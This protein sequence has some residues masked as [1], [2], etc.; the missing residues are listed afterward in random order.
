M[1][2]QD[3]KAGDNV[4]LEREGE[5]ITGIVEVD[6]GALYIQ[7]SKN[8]IHVSRLYISNAIKYGWK[9]CNI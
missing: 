6:G 3:I 9:I 4:T 5:T 2:L 8:E 1:T 7:I